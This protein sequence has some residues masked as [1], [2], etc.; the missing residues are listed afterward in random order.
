MESGFGALPG[1][2]IEKQAN[3]ARWPVAVCE[4]NA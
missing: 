2:M 4:V 3:E 1:S